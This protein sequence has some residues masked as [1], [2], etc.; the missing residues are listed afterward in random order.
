[1]PFLSKPLHNRCYNTLIKCSEFDSDA[2]VRAV[3]VTRELHPFRMGLPGENSRTARVTA[4]VEYLLDQ[5][6]EAGPPV[7]V[8]FLSALSGHY[9]HGNALL[10]ELKTLA[11]DV[12]EE[13]GGGAPPDPQHAPGVTVTLLTEILPTAYCYQLTRET[14]PLVNVTLDNTGRGGTSATVRVQAVIE[15][16]SDPTIAMSAVPQGTQTHIALLP[17]LRQEAVAALNEMRP[18]TLRVSV[19]QTT[20]AACLLHEQTYPIRLHARDT[21]LLAVQVVEGGIIDLSDYL[22]AWVTPRSPLMEQWL[23]RAAEH[24]PGKSIVGY[25]GANTPAEKAEVVRAQAQAIFTALK[26]EANLTYINSTLNMGRQAGQVTQ[27]VRLPGESLAAG[28]SANCIDGTVLFAS[29]LEL[30]SLEPLLVIVPGHALVGWRTW[31][32]VNQYE[33]L[34]TTMIGSS[35]FAAAQQKGQQ[36]YNDVLAKG[37][38]ARG[39]FDPGG[40]ARLV[41]IAACRGKGILPLE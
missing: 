26:Q 33:F 13:L 17:L 5:E 16:F 41:D 3:F 35:D 22:A 30:A 20:P 40:F 28:G 9:Q 15:G 11:C 18:T 4:V 12:E 31:R 37:Y 34:E 14:F 2:S 36:E 7:L 27:R 19:E 21:A 24:H 25:Q 38:F 6:P 39:L 32:G 1:M 29:L 23:R 10:N 8:L